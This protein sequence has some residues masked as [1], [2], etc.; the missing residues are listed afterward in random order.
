MKIA[1]VTGASSG[2]GQEFVRQID[3]EF[4]GLDEIWVIARRKERLLQLKEECFGKIVPI[5]LDLRD[6]RFLEQLKSMLQDAAPDVKL[7]IN[8]AGYGALGTFAAGRLEDEVG[9]IRL[10]CE[11]LT[12]ITHAVLP[13]MSDN[14]RII[15]MA[16][17]AAFVPQPKFAVY[18][19]TKAYVLSFSRALNRELK[20]RRISV[21]AVCPGPVKTEFFDVAETT[22]KI[23]IYKLV[24]MAD[25]KKVVAAALL[26][27]ACGKGL[28]VYG[29]SMKLFYAASK[30]LPHDI[31]LPFIR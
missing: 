21:T 2:I 4:K 10:N 27:S 23:A 12:A 15:Q 24:F 1:I 22:G 30:L 29:V 8:S 28:S 5:E 26:A 6:D 20:A 9:M 11:A 25:A 19:A 31:I 17:S 7:L 18:A 16:S 13:F 3:R 14:G